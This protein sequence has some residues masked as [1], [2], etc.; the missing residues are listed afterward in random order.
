MTPLFFSDDQLAEVLRRARLIEDDTQRDSYFAQVA[1]VLRGG[2]IDDNAV[3]RAAAAAF[4]PH[5]IHRKA[6]Q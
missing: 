4:A 2:P 5:A 1:D 6:A 3:H